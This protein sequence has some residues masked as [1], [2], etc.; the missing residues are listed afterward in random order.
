M[1]EGGPL[2]QMVPQVRE[3]NLD[4]HMLFL[5]HIDAKFNSKQIMNLNL[6]CERQNI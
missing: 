6:K 2:Q 5:V 4:L 1:E 3:Q